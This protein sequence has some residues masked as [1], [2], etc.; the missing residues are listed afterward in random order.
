MDRLD[1]L[2]LFV[3]TVQTGSFTR[4]GAEIGASQPQASRAVAA[5]EARLGARLL[6]RSTRRLSPTEAGQ[7][8]YEQALTLLAEEEA[9]IAAAAGADREPAGRLRVSASVVFGE[10]VLAPLLTDFLER[11]PRVRVDVAATDARLDLVAEGIDLAFRLGALS[12]SALTTRRL[13][14]YAR[15]LVGTPATAARVEADP[16]LRGALAREGI[17]FTGTTS[18]ARWRLTKGDEKMDVELAGRASSSNG[19]VVHRLAREG[20][21]VALLPSFAAQACVAEGKLVRVATDWT[22]EPVDLHAVWT[23]RALP[24]RARAFLDHVAPRLRL[25]AA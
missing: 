16:D 23:G 20:A 1:A 15:L 21:G 17:G 13:G 4:A 25:D 9:L 11:W 14:A 8:V 10:R 22:G 6:L 18:A 3:R 19:A 2:R 5:L 7:R 12:D 24:V